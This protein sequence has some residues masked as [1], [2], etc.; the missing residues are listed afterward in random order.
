MLLDLLDRYADSVDNAAQEIGAF[1]DH[2][3][4]VG[5]RGLVAEQLDDPDYVG[6]PGPRRRTKKAPA[7]T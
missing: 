7:Q 6:L 1:F 5:V 2:L 4:Q 3:R